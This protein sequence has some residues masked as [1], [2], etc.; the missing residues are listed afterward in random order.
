MLRK[1][2]RPRLGPDGGD[3]GRGGSV[4][5]KADHNTSCLRR[6]LPSYKA[7][8]GGEGEGGGSGR[9][10]EDVIL[11]VPCGT[12]AR[13]KHTGE[14]LCDLVRDQQE[15]II[16]LGGVAGLGNVTFKSDVNQ[17]PRE[18]TLGTAGEER[19]VV[20]EMQS[21]ADVGLVRL[22]SFQNFRWL[23]MKYNSH[24]SKLPVSG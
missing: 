19:D 5:L 16:A 24:I 13:D 23:V 3:G 1:S 12:V 21:I 9:G 6:L 14:L 18:A 20:L 22:S 15:H 2:N 4:I 10:A 8:R 17:T 11:L 7:K